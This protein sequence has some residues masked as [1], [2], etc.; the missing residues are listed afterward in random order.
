M[1]LDELLIA[2]LIH[3]GTFGTIKNHY[4]F[5]FRLQELGLIF[6]TKTTTRCVYK[7]PDSQFDL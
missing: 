3:Y 4:R 2:L 6:K 7:E 1:G 5:Q